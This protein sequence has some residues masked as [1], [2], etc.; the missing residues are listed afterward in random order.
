[1]KRI[2][3]VLSLVGLLVM[4]AA[5]PALAQDLVIL[6]GEDCVEV[7]VN[8]ADEETLQEILHIGPDRAGQIVEL[9]EEQPF[10]SFQ[11]LTRI[12]GINGEGIRRA[13]IVAQHEACLEDN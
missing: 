9:R 4:L 11:D 5:A 2:A 1:V 13:E 6:A 8:T 7:N 10:Q 12:S 3:L